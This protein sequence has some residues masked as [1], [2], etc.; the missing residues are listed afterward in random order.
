MLKQ[1]FERALPAETGTDPKGILEYV[2][3]LCKRE[4]HSVMILRNGKVIAEGWWK[5]HRPEDL[6]TLFS[7]SKS[8][9]S[10]AVGFAVSEGLMTVDMP[11][12]PEFPESPMK[13]D[14]HWEA[15]RVR[16]LLTM[17]MGHDQGSPHTGV[18]FQKRGKEPWLPAVLSEPLELM[19]GTRF[20]YDNRSSFLLG[21]LVQRK[22]GMTLHEYLK[23]RLLEPLGM[24]DS[25]WEE[26]PEGINVGAFGLNIRTEDLACFG[27]FLLQ[28]GCWNGKQLIDPEW[29]RQA[30]AKQVDNSYIDD[31]KD[32]RQGY[33]YQFWRCEPAGTFRGDG[34]W[35][36]NVLVLPEQ[37]A[38]VVY[39]SG[40][41]GMNKNLEAVWEYLLPA[42]EREP[43]SLAQAELER[44]LAGLEVRCPA[45]NSAGGEEGSSD[46]NGSY[47][48]EKNPLG[49][50]GVEL[51]KEY[52]ELKRADGSL[53]F[54]V[55]QTEW[56]YTDTG[57]G[58]EDFSCFCSD[59]WP[60]I[61]AKGAWKDGVWCVEL[62]WRETPF[63]DTVSFAKNPDG[64]LVMKWVRVP[65]ESDPPFDFTVRLTVAE[66][67]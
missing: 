40:C 47:V 55:G 65:D 32:W 23:P 64:D 11:V 45:E 9:L 35:G 16:H 5:P 2:N 3:E 50:L 7:L 66:K 56:A 46:L 33:G 57:Y 59:M 28:E 67:D 49:I 31:W 37:N 8:F 19:P 53:R 27:Q 60:K 15:L 13:G 38:V 14:A 39:T 41:T 1:R 10:M 24:E 26:S 36:Q 48:A 43:D 54:S 20:V 61:S 4:T 29:I 34:A 25:W 44:K 18:E 12:L 58:A 22:I 6:R 42:M 51:D 62:V 52:I 17:T 21:A 63:Q 30:T